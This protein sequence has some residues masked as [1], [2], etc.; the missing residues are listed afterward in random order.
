[1]AVNYFQNTL[2]FTDATLTAPGDGTVFQ[3]A[4]NNF[5]ATKSY[6]F[7]VTVAE[8]DTNVVVRLDASIDGT[9]YAPIIA[10]QTITS[11]GTYAYSVADRPVKFIKGV[12]VSESG[13][14]NSATVTFNLA[15]L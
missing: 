5:F 4:S 2:F 13:G 7:M 14:D 1:M 3:V 8:I 12:F 15:A 11:N 10:A 6:T 9:N